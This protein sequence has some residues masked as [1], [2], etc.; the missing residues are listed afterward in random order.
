MTEREL[1]ARIAL[2]ADKKKL[3]YHH[4]LDS[5]QC[6]GR[7][8]IP[9]LIIVGP[10][11]LILAELKSDDGETDAEQDLW[12]WT[13]E[14]VS[15]LCSHDCSQRGRRLWRIWTPTQLLDGTI[16]SDLSQLAS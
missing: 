1:L 9:D 8:G 12:I 7:G 3:L 4:C 5:R 2:L 14:Q 15:T 13:L 16:A 6:M 11:G 10:K